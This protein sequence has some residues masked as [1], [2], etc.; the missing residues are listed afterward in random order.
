MKVI[1]KGSFLKAVSKL[2]DK[3]LKMRIA[4]AI[5]DSENATSLD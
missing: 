5:E 2:S 4:K 3:R 1:F